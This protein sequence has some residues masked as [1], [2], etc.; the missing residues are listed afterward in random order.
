MAPPVPSSDSSWVVP[1]IV[2]GTVV[3]FMFTMGGVTKYWQRRRAAAAY[4]RLDGNRGGAAGASLGAI[5]RVPR[6]NA[7]AANLNLERERLEQI[8]K[9][10]RESDRHCQ[11]RRREDRRRLSPREQDELDLEELQRNHDELDEMLT[12]MGP[13]SSGPSLSTA[14]AAAA[15]GDAAL[16]RVHVAAVTKGQKS[17]KKTIKRL[18]PFKK[19]QLQSDEIEMKDLQ[20]QAD[21]VVSIRQDDGPD[22]EGG[23]AAAESRTDGPDVTGGAKARVRTIMKKLKASKRQ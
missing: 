19:R 2:I 22:I 13:P 18:L 1:L 21:V 3:A 15:A 14:A 9:E 8:R 12:S 23:A 7:L 17:F 11:D 20:S 4:Q 6:D 16:L 10:A 5:P